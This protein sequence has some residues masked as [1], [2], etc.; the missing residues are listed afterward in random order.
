M[1]PHQVYA[2]QAKSHTLL[3]LWISEREDFACLPTCRVAERCVCVCVCA[4]TYLLPPSL[5]AE[6]RASQRATHLDEALT[7]RRPR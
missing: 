6:A 4:R 1:S 3:K 5:F 2:S 7:Q